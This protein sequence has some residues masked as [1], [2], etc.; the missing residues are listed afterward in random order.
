[1]ECR[2]LVAA[3]DDTYF[4]TEALVLSLKW[5]VSGRTKPRHL[6]RAIDS[7]YPSWPCIYQLR[8]GGLLWLSLGVLVP[9]SLLGYPTGHTSLYYPR[10]KVLTRRTRTRAH[11][12]LLA[13]QHNEHNERTQPHATACHA[14]LSPS[15]TPAPFPLAIFY[16]PT[17]AAI[18]H[19]GDATSVN[20]RTQTQHHLP[21]TRLRHSDVLPLNPAP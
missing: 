7:V 16:T 11:Q 8:I 6:S 20:T 15:C 12:P 19:A 3:G 17:V 4:T 14:S 21:D 18:L 13:V 1:L 5:Q 2:V 9:G 10:C